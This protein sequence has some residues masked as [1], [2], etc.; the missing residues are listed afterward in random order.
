MP[1]IPE[2]LGGPNG[3]LGLAAALVLLT[4]FF[5]KPARAGWKRVKSFGQFLDA[6]N[7][8]EEITDRSGTVIQEKVPG[9]IA[10]LQTVEDSTSKISGL[11]SQM[12]IVH[13]E[14]TTNHGSSVKDATKRIEERLNEMAHKA[15]ETAEKLDEHIEIAI[16]SDHAQ[17]QTAE[18]VTK[19]VE[20]V[21]KLKSK[22]A[23][24]R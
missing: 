17:D 2:F 19:L 14:L 15:D 13:H 6:W 21:G 4:A 12:K 24:D 10:R 22:Y 20:D 5:W 18:Q 9:V 7:G 23:P 16:K 3:W 8:V 1:P 11:E